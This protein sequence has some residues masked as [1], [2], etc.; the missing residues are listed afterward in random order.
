MEKGFRVLREPASALPRNCGS[1][2]LRAD[3]LYLA[4]QAGFEMLVI[5]A[6]L[7]PYLFPLFFV[8]FFFHVYCS[9]AAFPKHVYKHVYIFHGQINLGLEYSALSSYKIF[10]SFFLCQCTLQLYKET[11]GWIS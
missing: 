9:R 5:P 1:C 7:Q 4:S 3:A 6:P 11:W 10:P 2:H 8:F